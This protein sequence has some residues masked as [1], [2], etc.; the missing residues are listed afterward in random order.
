MQPC[1]EQAIGWQDLGETENHE[2]IQKLFFL[3]G[4]WLI[5]VWI[6]GML[7]YWE[8]VTDWKD[9]GQTEDPNVPSFGLEKVLETSAEL[10]RSVVI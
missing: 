6:Q 5:Y 7:P 10:E 1:R 9:L 8:Q 2:G 3:A 4:T